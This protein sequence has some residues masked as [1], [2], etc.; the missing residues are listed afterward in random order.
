MTKEYL[1][2]VDSEVMEWVYF[3]PDDRIVCYQHPDLVDTCYEEYRSAFPADLEDQ[4]L[5]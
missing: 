4:M 2:K 3:G 1:V 5:D